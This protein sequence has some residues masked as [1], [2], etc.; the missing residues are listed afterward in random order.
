MG[1]FARSATAL[2]TIDPDGVLEVANLES[3]R[4]DLEA[5]AASDIV[6]TGSIDGSDP[7]TVLYA[8]GHLLLGSD[9]VGESNPLFTEKLYV[10]SD[11][12][13]HYIALFD[14][15]FRGTTPAGK[16]L[17]FRFSVTNSAHLLTFGG[18]TA[19][20][21]TA[22]FVENARLVALEQGRQYMIGASTDGLPGPANC[23]YISLTRRSPPID[24]LQCLYDPVGDGLTVDTTFRFRIGGFGELGWADG[25][26]P[27][28]ISLDRVAAGILALTGTLSVNERVGDPSA[29]ADSVKLYSKDVAGVSRLFARLSDGTVVPLTP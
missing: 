4:L 12:D 11:G 25:T 14:G 5:P 24:H 7:S 18:V 22:G 29:S 10:K 8:D 21:E 19:S 13:I 17:F 16:D 3:S 20:G 28:D 6:L 1:A 9:E 15:Q 26:N 27:Q 23:V 2:V